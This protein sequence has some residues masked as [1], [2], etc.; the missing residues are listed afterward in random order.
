[1]SLL[2][3]G[4]LLTLPEAGGDAPDPVTERVRRGFFQVAM[5]TEQEDPGGQVAAMFAA[6]TQPLLTCQV[7]HGRFRRPAHP[8]GT[9]TASA[10]GDEA[11][12]PQITAT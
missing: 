6:M 1:L 7:F 9:T 10:T 12:K 2:L 3:S 4:E 11:A 5:I 8:S